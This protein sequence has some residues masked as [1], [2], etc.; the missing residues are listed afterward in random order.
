MF[1]IMVYD[2]N[3]KRV[4][5]ILKTSRRYLS[6]VQNSVFEGD[7]TAGELKALKSELCKII[8]DKEDHILFYTWRFKNYTGKECIGIDKSCP[9][10][11]GI[12]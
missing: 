11:N 6:W 12:F 3:I 8:N 9:D 5:K 1:V 4:A 2:I 10:E 7:I